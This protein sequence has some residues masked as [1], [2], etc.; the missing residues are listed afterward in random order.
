[1]ALRL[2]FSVLSSAWSRYSL[3]SSGTSGRM[4]QSRHARGLEAIRGNTL[5]GSWIVRGLLP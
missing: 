5:P 1:M 3:T 4:E 2:D